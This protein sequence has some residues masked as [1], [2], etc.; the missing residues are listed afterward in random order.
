MNKYPSKVDTGLRGTLFSLEDQNSFGFACFFNSPVNQ[1]Y[2]DS[3]RHL[4]E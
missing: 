1:K 2:R 3:L 4:A